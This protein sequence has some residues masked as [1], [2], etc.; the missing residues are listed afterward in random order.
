MFCS[1]V[2]HL[3][4]NYSRRSERADSNRS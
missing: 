2:P 1:F 4:R 3:V